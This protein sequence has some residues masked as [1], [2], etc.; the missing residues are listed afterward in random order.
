MKKYVIAITI[1]IY[2]AVAFASSTKELKKVKETLKSIPATHNSNVLSVMHK[3]K[4]VL[5]DGFIDKFYAAIPEKHINEGDM[6]LSIIFDVNPPKEV[7]V[8]KVAKTDLHARFIKRRGQ[9]N[10]GADNGWAKGLIADDM[11]WR[12]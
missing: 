8:S 9:S 11:P 3:N 10:W 7:D 6:I 1:I 12:K 4:I 2:S 5:K